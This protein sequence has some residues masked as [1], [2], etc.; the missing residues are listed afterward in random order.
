MTQTGTDRSLPRLALRVTWF[1]VLVTV[2]IA[3]LSLLVLATGAPAW[4]YYG[5][6][7]LGALAFVRIVGFGEY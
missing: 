2:W 1:L 3:G 5:L 6:V 7:V 4:L